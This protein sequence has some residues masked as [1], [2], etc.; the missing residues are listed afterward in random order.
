MLGNAVPHA[1]YYFCLFLFIVFVSLLEP[2]ASSSN[3]P[4]ANEITRIF[5]HTQPGG[6]RRKGRIRKMRTPTPGSRAEQIA[7]G[8]ASSSSSSAAAARMV[9]PFSL[10]FSP[11]GGGASP[12]P[13]FPRWLTPAP[14]DGTAQLGFLRNWNHSVASFDAPS[15]RRLARPTVW[16]PVSSEYSL[17]LTPSRPPRG[18]KKRNGKATRCHSH[19]APFPR[20]IV[21]RRFLK[22]GSRYV[23]PFS[24]W[25]KKIVSFTNCT[26]ISVFL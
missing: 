22:T 21:F 17:A 11:V 16:D 12:I 18:R 15:Q 3:A 25:A 1:F 8:I 14:T 6:R 19:F 13:L 9:C 2:P 26:Y 24:Q 5:P 23:F 20:F 7:L 4:G 10:Y